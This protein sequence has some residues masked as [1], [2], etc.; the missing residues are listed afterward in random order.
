MKDFESHYL[1]KDTLSS[2]QIPRA[3]H[4]LYN[5]FCLNA[6]PHQPSFFHPLESSPLLYI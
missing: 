6:L 2:S 1:L 4:P 5:Q 3:I